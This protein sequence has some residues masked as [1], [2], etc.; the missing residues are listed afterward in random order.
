MIQLKLIKENRFAKW[1]LKRYRKI[2]L[3]T[4]LWSFPNFPFLLWRR[5]NE[6]SKT[7]QW[8]IKDISTVKTCRNLSQIQQCHF[9]SILYESLYIKLSH[10]YLILAELLF[11]QSTL[12]IK[13]VIF[14]KYII[15]FTCT[16]H[17]KQTSCMQ[18]SFWVH[19]FTFDFNS[20]DV[21]CLKLF[22][23]PLHNR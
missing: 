20:M 12:D 11:S 14:K 5:N 9:L 8:E 18:I 15:Q 7:C 21:H 17:V 6:R 19:I 10:N 1:R 4:R 22:N 3:Q 13:N 16:E 23:F 2:H